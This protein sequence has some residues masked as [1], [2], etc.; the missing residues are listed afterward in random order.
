MLILFAL[1]ST[2]RFKLILVSASQDVMF[3]CNKYI[4]DS[5]VSHN[6]S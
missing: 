4:D 5:S 3:S 1:F 6:Y 2:Y